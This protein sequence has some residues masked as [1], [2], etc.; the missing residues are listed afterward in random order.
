M[1]LSK[2]KQIST[3]QPNEKI[4]WDN[5]WLEQCLIPRHI[6]V[7][8]NDIRHSKPFAYICPFSRRY[9]QSMLALSNVFVKYCGKVRGASCIRSHSTISIPSKS[10]PS[11]FPVDG[12]WVAEV[13]GGNVVNRK[14]SWRYINN[15]VGLVVIA[16]W[17]ATTS[18]WNNYQPQWR[19]H[20]RLDGCCHCPLIQGLNCDRPVSRWRVWGKHFKCTGLE[21]NLRNVLLS[22]CQVVAKNLDLIQTISL[23]AL[24][25]P[26]MRHITRNC[27]YIIFIF[28]SMLCQ[29]LNPGSHTCKAGTF[30]DWAMSEL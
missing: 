3:A 10:L 25:S 5:M 17:F 11:F 2:S 6:Y 8:G 23:K 4:P 18:R 13:F 9:S 14:W 29:E 15:N 24:M 16:L 12:C 27:K 30:Y 28:F 7:E 22:M 1:W 20:Y 26:I 19:K 21:V